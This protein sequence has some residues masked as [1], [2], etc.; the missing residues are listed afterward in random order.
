MSMTILIYFIQD[1]AFE[2][3]LTSDLSPQWTYFGSIIVGVNPA[4]TVSAVRRLIANHVNV[5]CRPY[6]V[7]IPRSS[8]ANVRKYT[9]HV[10]CILG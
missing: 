7:C 10:T 4:F 1:I 3:Q 2:M 5:D 6:E 9:L 8:E